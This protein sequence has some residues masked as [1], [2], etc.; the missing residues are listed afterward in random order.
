MQA[1]LNG[2]QAIQSSGQAVDYVTLLSGHDYPLRPLRQ[3][4][5]FLQSNPGLEHLET[6]KFAFI[7]YQNLLCPYPPKLSS[8]TGILLKIKLELLSL[9][10]YLISSP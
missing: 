6:L 3:L 5:D 2:L 1:T 10:T 7:R 8:K 9:L 4:Q